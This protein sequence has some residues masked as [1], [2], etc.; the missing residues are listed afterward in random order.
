MNNQPD[1]SP[2]TTTW[3]RA[4]L[5]LLT[6]TACSLPA[7]FASEVSSGMQGLYHDVDKL[8]P[9]LSVL[10][11][12]LLYFKMPLTVFGSIVLVMSPGL[13]FALALN[14]AKSPGM[15]A[16]AGFSISLVLVSAAAAI[17]QHL[18]GN[19]VGERYFL[20][21]IL[22][23]LLGGLFLFLRLARGA[24]LQ[25]P[26]LLTDRAGYLLGMVVIPIIF[27]VI[28]TPKF[29]WESFNGDGAH[30][31][32]A[33]RLLLH[34][35][36]PFWPQGAGV[37]SNFPGLNSSLF[38]FP[39]SWF[40]RLFGPFEAAVRL[41]FI[42]YIGL[43]HAAVVTASMA[44]LKQQL[45]LT[46]HLLISLS[47]ASVGLVLSYSA[48]YD[49]YSADIALTATQD[50]LLLVFTLGVV[51][52]FI[53]ERPW[54]MLANIILVLLA[55]PGGPLL[56]GGWL[57]G[58]LIAYRKRPWRMIRLYVICL[59]GGISLTLMLPTVLA[60]LGLPVPGN[61]HNV[62]ALLSKFDHLIIDDFRRFA[63]IL[64]P[65]GI[66]PVIAML[67][68]RKADDAGRA[69]IVVTL[70]V[71]TVYY[72]IAFVSLHYFIAAMV[73][74]IV[75]FWRQNRY[76]FWVSPRTI[77]GACLVAVS[78][79]IMA[80]L[81]VSTAIYTAPREIGESI[82]VSRLHGYE[83]MSAGAF[84]SSELI[85]NLFGSDALPDVPDTSY[86]VSPL[87]LFYY[88][89]R[90]TKA[91]GQKNYLLQANN[92]P[93]EV[94]TLVAEND[95]SSIFVKDQQLWESQRALRPPGSQGPAVY[96]VPR[97]LLFGRGNAYKDHRI[98]YLKARLRKM[99]LL[100]GK[101]E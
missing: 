58:V 48:T 84:R 91:A 61:E 96:A 93:P 39:S 28:F 13:V 17:T 14:Q 56:L 67:G 50:V 6:L 29:F 72:M 81:P 68:W 90:A 76:E 60:V 35:S 85:G 92:H 44:R 100:P 21:I 99:N 12:V 64:I 95:I 57:A 71:F 1:S 45:G 66:Y 11:P 3:R 31:Y 22:L 73:I 88:A 19:L 43:L 23:L 69:L 25:W 36:L 87:A 47:V 51:T 18:F 94:M 2:E 98:I 79:S 80:A 97:D 4:F 38:T 52:S 24:Q 40:I 7:F 101:K 63:Y 30:A 10:D 74:P 49:P 86:G 46:G 8:N 55:S 20:V 82:D 5:L 16:L 78:V 37:A 77:T 59:A 33:A 26:D 62:G 65:C 27:L 9:Y 70:A 42:L 41:P 34:Q 75:I 32:E 83:T 15:W 53:L 54:W 89:H